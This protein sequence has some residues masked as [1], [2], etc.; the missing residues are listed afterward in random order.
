MF[1]NTSIDVQVDQAIL[2]SMYEHLRDGHLSMS[3][4]RAERC[5]PGEMTKLIPDEPLMSACLIRR[6]LRSA[7]AQFFDSLRVG[8][9]CRRADGFRTTNPRMRTAL[10]WALWRL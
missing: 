5:S 6:K 8:E 9:Q 7:G 1:V 3:H 4:L 2:Q 10:D